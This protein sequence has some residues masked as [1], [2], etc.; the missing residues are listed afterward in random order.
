M[1]HKKDITGEVPAVYEQERESI[2][3]IRKLDYDEFE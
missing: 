2:E 1:Y 3:M